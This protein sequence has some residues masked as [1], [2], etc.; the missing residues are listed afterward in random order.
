[1][2]MESNKVTDTIKF[3]CS[4]GGKILPRYTD[5][6][7]RYVGGLT[8]VLSVDRSISYTELMVK[9][10]E[11]CGYSVTLRCQLPSGDL[12]TLISITSDEDLANL[13]E[14]YNRASSSMSHPLKI[15]AVLS[16]PKSLKKISPPP[17]VDF[18]ASRSPFVTA[19]SLGNSAAYHYVPRTYSPPIGYPA[20]A[21][22][23]SAKGN[24]YR[25]HV[26]HN[27]RVLYSYSHFV[28]QSNYRY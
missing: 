19:E 16:P 26:Q 8:R 13:I 25:Y 27:P 17:S 15:R 4:Y 20:G 28:P 22:N 5:G 23:C 10:G 11:F 21:R 7:L 18:S 12:E 3:L 14:E 2:G 6:E 9:L 1:M 24:R